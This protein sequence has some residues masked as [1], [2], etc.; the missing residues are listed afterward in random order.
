MVIKKIKTKLAAICDVIMNN[1]IHCGFGLATN[2]HFECFDKD[3]NLKWEERARNL[4]VNA[5]LD[6][7]LDKYFKGS[8]YTAAFF[9]GLKDTGV[10]VAA[11][12][13]ASHAS[14]A[15][16]SPYSNATDPAL[17]LGSVS[18]QSVDNSASKASFTIN[19]TDEVF[20]AFLKDN[21]TVDG[22]T[23]L[24]YGVVDF[25]ASR[26]VLSGDTLNVTITLTSASV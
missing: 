14:W 18:S 21:N 5:G 7:V 23:G 19:E 26:N 8:G 9:V 11:D 12:T 15:T 4:I 22:A 2:Y 24:L 20:G 3:G 17:T 6:D 13:M 10:A 1:K 25:V 16:I